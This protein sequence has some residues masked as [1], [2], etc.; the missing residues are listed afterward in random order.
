[1]YEWLLVVVVRCPVPIWFVN[2]IFPLFFFF[3][4]LLIF[5]FIFNYSSY[6]NINSN[7]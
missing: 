2:H 6:L 4:I 5:L 7:I 3:V 1:M